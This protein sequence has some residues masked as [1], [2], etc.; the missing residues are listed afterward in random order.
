MPIS[1]AIWACVSFALGMGERF[2]EGLDQIIAER[3]HVVSFQVAFSAAARAA[4]VRFSL[5]V[6]SGC[7]A[8][9]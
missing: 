2:R 3:T 8:F 9:A 4:T 1:G 6:K 7:L 5:G